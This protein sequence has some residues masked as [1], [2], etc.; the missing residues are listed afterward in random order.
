MNS[1]ANMHMKTASSQSHVDCKD[2]SF[3]DGSQITRRTFCNELLLTSTV[4]VLWASPIAGEAATLQ[5]SIL[6]Y[7]PRKI[8]GAERLI[9]GTSLYFEY[10]TRNDPAV[11]LRSSE[12]EYTAYSRKCSHAGCSVE[13]DATRRCLK[14]PCHQ[15]TFDARIGHVMYGPPRRPLDQIVLQL[16][17]G[18][19]VWA[20]GKSIGRNA[21]G[22][23]RLARQQERGILQF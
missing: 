12:G 4:I 5:E 22:L 9:A 17:S 3:G 19:Q 15:G 21:E 10:P 2:D 14:C 13:F 20:V 11:L 23:A 7:P 1:P 6:A 18:G 16:R 8:E